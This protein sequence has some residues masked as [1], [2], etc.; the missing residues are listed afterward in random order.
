MSSLIKNNKPIPLYTGSTILILSISNKTKANGAALMILSKNFRKITPKRPV[1]VRVGSSVKICYL[2]KG[3]KECLGNQC[4]WA[5]VG[6]CKIYTR[7]NGKI[8]QK[9]KFRYTGKAK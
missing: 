6:T 7:L 9:I 8:P 4:L 2:Y 5:R 1:V 3:M